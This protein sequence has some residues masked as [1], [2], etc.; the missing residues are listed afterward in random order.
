M[1]NEPKASNALFKSSVEDHL[2]GFNYQT[3]TKKSELSGKVLGRHPQE[4]SL[5]ILLIR[6][7]SYHQLFFLHNSRHGGEFRKR[8]NL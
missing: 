8:Q 6:K 2:E 4:D 7:G 5:Q 1:G 3:L